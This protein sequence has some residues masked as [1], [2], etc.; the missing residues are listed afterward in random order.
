MT[1]I[2]R[3]TILQ[4]VVDVFEDQT[5]LTGKPGIEVSGNNER[6]IKEIAAGLSQKFNI[7]VTIDDLAPRRSSESPGRPNITIG[8][9]VN[10]VSLRL[11]N[12]SSAK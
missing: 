7:V 4:D 12:A 3:E 1:T 11:E 5:G 6:N 9:I 2:N 10:V 8:H